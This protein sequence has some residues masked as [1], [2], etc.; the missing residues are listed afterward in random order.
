MIAKTRKA[1]AEASRPV[2]VSLHPLSLEQA[3]GAL[4]RIPH[5]GATKYS[6][7]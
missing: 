7:G 5:S 6:G 2:P 4:L 3:L 1:T